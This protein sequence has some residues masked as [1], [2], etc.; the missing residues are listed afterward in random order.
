MFYV[1]TTINSFG[2]KS[3]WSSVALVQLLAI[4]TLIYPGLRRDR[5]KVCEEIACCWMAKF[6]SAVGGEKTLNFFGICWSCF[7]VHRLSESLSGLEVLCLKIEL[8]HVFLVIPANLH[9]MERSRRFDGD[10]A[11]GSPVRRTGSFPWLIS[12][13]QADRVNNGGVFD[14]A[15]T[16]SKPECIISYM[17]VWIGLWRIMK[18]YIPPM[19]RMTTDLENFNFVFILKPYAVSSQREILQSPYKILGPTVFLS[20]PSEFLCLSELANLIWC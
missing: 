4:N 7:A 5:L 14:V 10:S 3:W 16:R 2:F 13:P 8:H 18:I 19:G 20:S 15:K 17:L 6:S 11:L 1:E 9:L 12:G